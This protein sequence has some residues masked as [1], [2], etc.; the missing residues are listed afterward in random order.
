MG[1][2]S[3]IFD[4]LK[5]ATAQIHEQIEGRV[6][7]F[8]PHFD[9]LRY[10]Q[11]LQ[12]FYGFWAPL[13]SKLLLVKSLTHPELALRTRM[14]GHLLEADLRIMGHGRGTLPRCSALPVIRTFASGLGCLYV[15][16]GSRRGARIIPPI[17]K[18]P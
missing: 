1:A 7:V 3:E 5:E 2:T 12:R 4:R 13:E 15:L 14:K 11:L 10:G 18:P 17:A 16:E 8:D 9:L 6:P